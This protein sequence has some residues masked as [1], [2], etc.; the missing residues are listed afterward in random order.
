MITKED[1][2]S[3][4]TA[5]MLKE[6]GYNEATTGF[7]SNIR[8]LCIGTAGL[9]NSIK[10][11]FEFVSYDFRVLSETR[12]S[13]PTLYEAQKWI[14]SKNNIFIE[15]SPIIP[16]DE[17]DDLE[18][19]TVSLYYKYGINWK[20]AGYGNKYISYQQALNAGIQEAIN[21]IK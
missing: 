21:L 12:I 1:Y 13:A 5:K 4:E 2:V 17:Q 6:K 11:S 14:F 19:F 9:Y 18:I 3:L 8:G 16:K 15:V 7:Y 20:L 10:N